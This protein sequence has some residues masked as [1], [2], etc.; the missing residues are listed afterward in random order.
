VTTSQRG[1]EVFCLAGGGQ[2]GD[3][4]ATGST[5]T[6][7]KLEDKVS[8]PRIV[9]G[10]HALV[11]SPRVTAPVVRATAT[12]P[13]TTVPHNVTVFA[14]SARTGPWIVELTPI[15]VPPAVTVTGPLTAGDDTYL[16]RQVAAAD[17]SAHR[18]APR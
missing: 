14:A 12:G 15:R 17:R 3:L 2:G 18:A 10:E 5:V 9:F 4:A 11:R 7:P 6:S 13:S 1:Q 16:T 8:D